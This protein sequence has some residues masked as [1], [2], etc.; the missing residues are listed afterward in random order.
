MMSLFGSLEPCHKFPPPTMA[1]PILGD[2]IAGGVKAIVELVGCLTFAALMAPDEL[3]PFLP[4]FLN[5][6]LFGFIVSQV[7]YNLVSRYTTPARTCNISA[8]IFFLEV[9]A[10]CRKDLAGL[11][12]QMD[13]TVNTLLMAATIT[14]WMSGVISWVVGTFKLTQFVRYLSEPVKLGMQVSLGYFLFATGFSI[15]TGISWLNFTSLDEFGVYFELDVLPKWSLTTAC[16]LFIFFALNKWGWPY[17]IPVFVGVGVGIFHIILLAGGFTIEEAKN[18][19]WLYP[20]PA[21]SDEGYNPFAFIGRIY[22]I[23]QI[24]WR[25]LRFNLP[26]I[27]S[28]ALVSPFLSAVIN[29]ILFESTFQAEEFGKSTLSYELRMDGMTQWLLAV[30]GGYSSSPSCGGTAVH[31]K[32]GARSNWG[33][34]SACIVHS[35]FLLVPGSTDVLQFVPKYVV[36]AV[37]LIVAISLLDSGLRGGYS[38]LSKQEYA[39]VCLTMLIS[40]FFGIERGIAGGWILSFAIFI[41]Q[42][43]ATAPLRL[44]VDAG[45]VCSHAIWGTRSARVVAQVRGAVRML[46]FQGVLFFAAIQPTLK[47]EERRHLQGDK[48]FFLILDFSSVTGMDDSSPFEFKNFAVV[49]KKVGVSIVV[50]G[51][52]PKIMKKLRKVGAVPDAGIAV[53]L[54]DSEDLSVPAKRA[55]STSGIDGCRLYVVGSADRAVEFCEIALAVRTVELCKE[56]VPKPTQELEALGSLLE[57]DLSCYQCRLERGQYLERKEGEIFILTEGAIEAVAELADAASGKEEQPEVIVVYR[58][59]PGLERD[60]CFSAS[61]P[62]ILRAVTDSV[63]VQLPEGALSELRRSSRWG[64]VEAVWS[65]LAEFMAASMHPMAVKATMQDVRGAY[66]SGAAA[67]FTEAVHEQLKAEGRNPVSDAGSTQNQKNF[68]RRLFIGGGA[69]LRELRQTISVNSDGRRPVYGS[70]QEAVPGREQPKTPARQRSGSRKS[71]SGEIYHTLDEAEDGLS[72]RAKAQAIGR[73][74]EAAAAELAADGG[75][76]ATGEVDL[77]MITDLRDQDPAPVKDDKGGAGKRGREPA[78]RPTAPLRSESAVDL[79]L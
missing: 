48:T 33:L 41:R 6:A 72:I 15:S 63:I 18:S 38:K 26:A 75:T 67:A 1:R 50:C 54:L 42:I 40:I 24:S 2:F 45:L 31:R 30:V 4:V 9:L 59:L 56:V 28:A 43:S 76:L 77:D 10:S 74:A 61:T 47:E 37:S 71:K 78:D 17:T 66:S 34:F 3:Q 12:N 49:A 11:P 55:A 73:P 21:G 69:R 36:G 23:D 68:F 20:P 7:Y 16:A 51:C 13:V 14:T 52:D 53:E 35:A 19:G 25:T 5:Y 62:G 65:Q 70:L 46:S 57:G 79:T 58:T 27:A 29:L 64:D 8:V 22:S 32:I 39:V 60:Y 44:D